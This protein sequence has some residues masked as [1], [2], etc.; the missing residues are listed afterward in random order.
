MVVGVPRHRTVRVVGDPA[1]SALAAL[2]AITR[3]LA[4]PLDDQEILRRVHREL[5]H[6]LD[7][8]ICFFG[9]Y[10]EPRQMVDVIWQIH[11]GT[12]LPG[13]QFPLGSGVTSQVLRTR[14]PQ[15][16]RNWSRQAPAVQVQY[17]TEH[18]DLPSSAIVVPVVFNQRVLGV[19]SIQN[20][21]PDAFTADDMVLVQDAMGQAAL[22]LSVAQGRWR[23]PREHRSR[24][25]D[26]QALVATM[27][28]GLVVLDP[29]A[30]LLHVNRA[31]RDLLCLNGSSLIVG[32]PVDQDQAGHWP[33]GTADVTQALRPIIDQLKRGEDPSQDVDVPL[34][35]QPPRVAACRGSVVLR[36][37]TPAGGVLILH[38]VVAQSA[39]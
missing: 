34:Q 6:V 22:A 10:D 5:N 16:I 20:Y 28:A 13:G 24:T 17:A 4:E 1:P 9:A 14:E 3:A 21:R 23:R 15:L 29:D 2:R 25:S 31:A 35:G 19:L 27:T 30:R 36:E 8:E 39:N 7:A 18:A 11:R 26:V 33:L 32:H 12:E 38:E 37:G